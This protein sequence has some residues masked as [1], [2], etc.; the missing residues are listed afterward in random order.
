MRCD[1]DGVVP[2]V[3]LTFDDGPG[4]QTAEILDI[5][6]DAGVK[7]TFFVLGVNVE[8]APWCDG[9]AARSRS[10]VVR[11][12]REGHVVGNHSFTHGKPAAYLS[13]AEEIAR[14]D[15]VIRARRK[16]AGVP[17]DGPIPVRLPYGIR[18]VEQT[19]DVP[20]G[21]LN[22]V[23]LD[24]RLPVLASLGRTHVHWTADFSDWTALPTDGPDLAA[25]MID[26]VER[27]A[28]LGFDAVLDLHDSGTGSQWGYARPATATAVRLFLTEA[29]RRG[30]STF[31]VPSTT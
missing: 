29:L 31:T 16:D 7:A 5:L 13:L 15:R 19:L 3:A 11:A 28:E 26:H 8:E 1:Y 17:E 12:L 18:L 25:R 20:T 14:T 10:L 30:W 24:T 27:N 6:R 21:T 23:A 22:I 2:R 4:P 9:D